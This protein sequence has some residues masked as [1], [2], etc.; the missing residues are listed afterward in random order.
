MV[1]HR[2][3][4]ESV[5]QSAEFAGAADMLVR[6]GTPRSVSTCACGPI[7]RSP[8]ARPWPSPA[9]LAGQHTD[10]ILTELGYSAEAIADLRERKVVA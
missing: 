8:A 1:A 5:L 3:P 2:E 4:P 9:L 6:W 7:C 10:T